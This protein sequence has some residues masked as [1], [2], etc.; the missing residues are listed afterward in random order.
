MEQ[1]RDFLATKLYCPNCQASMPVTERLLLVLPDCY[2]FE[3]LCENCGEVL[4][5]KKTSLKDKDK[6]LF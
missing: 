3:Y 5:D 1:Y 4:G 2:L 6:L